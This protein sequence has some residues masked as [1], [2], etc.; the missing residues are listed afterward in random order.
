VSQSSWPGVSAWPTAVAWPGATSWPSGAQFPSTVVPAVWL[1]GSLQAYSDAAG[2]LPVSAGLIRRINEASAATWLSENDPQRPSRDVGVRCD[3]LA[4]AGF[5][6]MLRGASTSINN[7]NWTMVLQFVVRDGFGGQN[8]GFCATSAT[9]LGLAVGA[10]VL[11]CAINNSISYFPVLSVPR[12]QKC[13]AVVRGTASG[14]TDSLLSGG[15]TQ[16]DSIAATVTGGTTGTNGWHLAPAGFGGMNGLYGSVNQF[17]VVNRAVTDG[18]AAQ[19]LAWGDS[20]ACTAGYPLTSPLIGVCGDSIAR[21]GVGLTPQAGWCWIMLQTLRGGVSPSAEEC[22]VAI[23]GSGVGPAM[24]SALTPF[25][26]ASRTKNV[27]FLASGTNDLANG[28]GAA[29]TT[30]AYFAACDTLRAQG[31]K[32]IACTILPRSDVMV[33]SQ[34]TYNTARA[35]MNASIVAGN[36]HYDGLADVASVTGMGADGDSNNATNY[37]GDNVH[38]TAVGHGLI[39]PTYRTA[40]TPFV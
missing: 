38:P 17:L 29:A 2:T 7:N 28:N 23:V 14:A 20:L 1:D 11:G 8:M 35:T 6:Q 32:V 24:Y 26:S 22:N 36:S 5:G 9:L 34:V 16:T 15:V 18:E 37:Q 25:Y 19:L 40:V 3:F 10:G 33:V 31:W 4:G 21:N 39:E 12:A 13:T 30:T 27:V